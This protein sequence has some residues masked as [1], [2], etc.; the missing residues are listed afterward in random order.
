[1]ATPQTRA[2]RMRKRVLNVAHHCLSRSPGPHR[3][4]SGGNVKAP[5]R[6]SPVVAPDKEPAPGAR[7]LVGAWMARPIGIYLAS[8]LVVLVAAGAAVDITSGPPVGLALSR[9]WDA[10]WYLTLAEHGYPTA[11]S[12]QAGPAG[13][14]TLGFFP[15]HPLAVRLAHAVGLPW[16]AASL[17]VAGLAGLG[18]VVLL[19]KLLARLSGP[20][21][22]DRGVA[23]WCFFPGSLFLSMGYAEPLMLLFVVGCLWA[24]LERRW[25][26]A[27]ALGALATATR[28][29]GLAV[30]LPCLWAAAVAIRSRREWRALAAPLLAPAGLVAFF[31]YLLH[32]T[33]EAD[34]YLRTQHDAWAQR[35]ELFSGLHTVWTFLRHPFADDNFTLAVAGMVFIALAAWP[36][37]RSRPP[38]IFL[39]YTAGAVLLALVNTTAPDHLTTTKPR[40]LLT[41]FPLVTAL[42]ERLTPMGYAAVLGGFATLLGAFTV[43]TLAS[44]ALTTP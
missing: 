32:H 3:L 2:A 27:G 6:P 35:R 14:T 24:L 11:V 8:R 40:I 38:G 1:M 9:A 7:R 17:V 36:L 28:P 13:Q 23:L 26:L 30:V 33:G 44:G 19:W 5:L 39:A 20:G 15:L 43:I 34:A 37:L 25:V 22:A 18:T 21:A 41:A 10:G 31:L 16:E 42:G 29:N 4:P 12:A